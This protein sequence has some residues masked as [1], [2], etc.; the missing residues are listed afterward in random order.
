[1]DRLQAEFLENTDA[2]YATVLDASKWP[3]VLER[4]ARTVGAFGSM[5][6][7]TDQVMPDLEITVLSERIADEE[8]QTY[9]RSQLSSDELYWVGALDQVPALTVLSDEQIWPEREEYDAMPSVDWLRSWNL[10]HRC[11]VRLCAHGGWRD[12]IA[13]VYSSDRSGMTKDEGGRL[14]SLLPHMARAMEIRRPFALLK[15]RYR[16]IL[17]VLDRLGIG[18]LVLLDDDHILLA[19]NEAERILDAG[20]GLRRGLDGKLAIPQRFSSCPPMSTLRGALAEV[21]SG[22][23]PEGTTLYIDRENGFDPYVIDIAVFHENGIELGSPITATL[24]CMIDPE[25][26]DVISTRG[27]EQI[28]GLTAAESAVCSL[29]G[30]GHSN[31]E[32]ADIRGV[33]L[34][35]V[36]SQTKAIYRKTLCANRI[37]LVQ[38]ALS[39]APPLLDSTGRRQK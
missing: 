15:S 16:A 25:R 36:K 33:H 12:T 20:D 21:R 4:A 11:A 26:R 37:E 28:Y 39:I 7:V 3:E 18:V 24:L 32:I 17:S 2:I 8:A 27:L 10:Y 5:L 29:M 22:R 38:R 23:A 14:D 30:A 34:D 35:T 9:V 6:M 31:R 1:M 13:T 19:N